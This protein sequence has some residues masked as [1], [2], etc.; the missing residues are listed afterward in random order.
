MISKSCPILQVYP[1]TD[2]YQFPPVGGD[3]LWKPKPSD[4]ISDIEIQGINVWQDFKLIVILTECLRQKGNQVYQGIL[5]RACN[6]SLT[7][8][9]VDLLNMY[10][11]QCRK[12]N[13]ELLPDLSISTKN[14]LRHE[15]NFLHVVDFPK[16]RNQKVYI[17]AA[18]HKLVA[19]KAN[20]IKY[21]MQRQ[22]PTDVSFTKMLELQDTNCWIRSVANGGIVIT[23]VTIESW[24]GLV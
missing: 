2:F 22:I 13:G 1:L 4:K 12:S 14:R 21:N 18:N 5:E 7:Q 9:D 8:Q 17:F 19:F 16:A 6:V 23:I 10:T 11:V 20:L 24:G 15:L 3:P